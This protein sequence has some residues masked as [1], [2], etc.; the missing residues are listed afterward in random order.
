[1]KNNVKTLSL[2]LGLA[3]LA[4]GQTTTAPIYSAS[5]LA[6]VP[7]TNGLGDGG[8]ST[9]GTVSVPEG[10]AVDPNGNIY[11]ADY[12]NS[13]IRRIDGTTGIITTL[14]NTTSNC[15]YYSPTSNSS[16]CLANPIALAFDQKGDLL[17]TQSGNS[18]MILRVTTVATGTGSS[19]VPAGTI[20]ELAGTNVSGTYGGDG[21]Y[22]YNSV[23]NTPAGIA[24]D[25]ADNIYISDSSN[26]R[27]R[28]VPNVNNCIYTPGVLNSGPGLTAAQSNQ[29][30][31]TC[32]VYTIAGNG[33]T[34][35]PQVGTSCGTTNTCVPNGT[36][37]VGDGGP[38]LAARLGTPWGIAVTPNG[39]TVYVAQNADQ[40][41]RAINMLTGTISTVIGN[42]SNS[43]SSS[44]NAQGGNPIIIPCPSGT[45][46]TASASANGTN[47]L[48]DGRLAVNGTVNSPRGLYLDN[49]NGILWFADASN[50]RIRNVNLNTGIVS[51]AIGGGPSGN[52]GDQGAGLNSGFL[53]NLAL[54]SPYAIWVQ[55]GLI[56]WVEQA[57]NKVRVADPI[58]QVARTLTSVPKSTGSG[59]PAT[60]ALLGFGYSVTSSGSP[61]VAVDASGNVYIVE[62]STN[63]I[64][65]VNS[66][67]VINEWAGTGA[68]A[69]TSKTNGDSG[70]AVLAQLSA[71][72]SV[73]FDSN[74]NAYIADTGINRIRMVT[75]AGV[76]STV[77][78]R[79]SV[80]TCNINTL[81][82]NNGAVCN[83][84]TFAADKS[85]YVGDGGPPLNAVLSGPQGI[86]VD[87]NNNLIIADTGHHAIRYVNQTAGVITTIAGGVPAGIV[88]GP[89]DGRSGLGTS[90]I[91][92]S[93]NALYGLFNNPRG[94][95]VDKNGNIYVSDYSNSEARIL[96][97]AGNGGYGLFS[98]Y[99]SGSGS[100]TTPSIPTGTGA[101]SVPARIRINS[102]NN[103]SVAVDPAGNQYYALS[104][105]SFGNQNG[106]P[107]GG[108]VKVVAADQSRVYLVAGTTNASNVGGVQTGLNYTTGNAG[109]IQVPSVS[110]VAVDSQGNVYTA[111]RTG[112]VLKLTCTK[113]C[114]PVH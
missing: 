54:N 17:V 57:N 58:A 41:I 51:T 107:D 86:A 103:V 99:G 40:R 96:V 80:T 32:K 76:I 73:A 39:Q 45:Y 112:V 95:A 78:G 77:V 109:N 15:L 7:S 82:D 69:S 98:Y 25:A 61:R 85:N 34:I 97:P 28:M 47:T 31:N 13:R 84:A 72:Q 3:S 89:T 1:M 75:P 14:A 38:A 79:N 50:N 8:P 74:G 87:A 49:A 68:A 110:G 18:G 20:T 83:P 37:S 66:S 24:T 59:G 4:L 19:A 30:S 106:G 91:L 113:N 93:T 105:D 33:N 12:N 44:N 5:I 81:K 56:Y 23:W 52:T 64:R 26:N 92:D 16:P 65:Q 88:N 35:T 22:F 2:C 55:N 101:P 21:V 63:K 90:G 42:C 53:Q 102:T 48:G 6:G 10:I 62:A 104:S 114:L 71:P 46:G 111:D 94:V 60:S 11:V 70:P 27:V 9:F 108:Q 100:G 43:T 36:N 29:M 67:G